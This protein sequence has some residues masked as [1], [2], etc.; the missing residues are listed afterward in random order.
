MMTFTRS[1]ARDY[2][3]DHTEDVMSRLSQK[4]QK[5]WICPFPGCDHGARDPNSDGIMLNPA[6]KDGCGLKCFKCGFAGDVFDLYQALHGVEFPE[7]LEALANDLGIEISDDYGSTYTPTARSGSAIDPKPKKEPDDWTSKYPQWREAIKTDPHARQY[8]K[9]RCIS[10]GTAVKLGMGYADNLYFAR[11]IVSPGEGVCFE[12][13]AIGKAQVPKRS[14]GKSLFNQSALFGKRD[15]FIAEG[16]FDVASLV[17]V[18]VDH[19]VGLNSTSE[20]KLFL[21]ALDTYK[22][23]TNFILALD[24]DDGGRRAAEEIKRGLKDRGLPFLSVKYPEAAPGEEPIKDPNEFLVRDREAFQKAVGEALAAAQAGQWEDVADREERPAEGTAAA[25]NDVQEWGAIKPYDEPNFPPPPVDVMPA[26]LKEYIQASADTFNVPLELPVMITLAALATA[27]QGNFCVQVKRKWIETLSLLTLVCMR[28]GSGKT[29]TMTDAIAP[30]LAWQR[31]R[32]KTEVAALEAANRKNEAIKRQRAAKTK[33][34]DKAL[35]EGSITMDEYLEGQEDMPNFV[36]EP[37]ITDIIQS[38]DCTDEKLA[39]VLAKQK[40]VGFFTSEGKQMLIWLGLYT[41]GVPAAECVLRGSCGERIQVARKTIGGSVEADDPRLS[42][43]YALQPGVL[44]SLPPKTKGI[45]RSCGFFPRFQMAYAPAKLTPF[46]YYENQMPEEVEERYGAMLQALLNHEPKRID[47]EGK[48]IP[49]KY[50]L[51][52]FTD[53]AKMRAIDYANEIQY[54][55]ADKRDKLTG[56]AEWAS[57]LRGTL[58]RIAALFYLCDAA[59][60]IDGGSL[61]DFKAWDPSFF[62]GL[63]YVEAAIKF[64]NWLVPQEDYCYQSIVFSAD[65]TPKGVL[66]WIKRKGLKEFSRRD[67]FNMCRHETAIGDKVENLQLLLEDLT[68]RN[69]IKP[70]E[71]PAAGR[72]KRGRPGSPRYSVNPAF[73]DLP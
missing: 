44:A 20:V 50:S 58:S 39:Q 12:A 38:G 72:K 4:I 22:P 31:E 46:T 55:L 33:A 48:E 32:R 68:E 47:G 11:R 34:L 24:N 51:L 27:A 21:E 14:N 6:S 3:R 19:A 13:R 18:G 1:A 29:A 67:C 61:D 2:I 49:A 5:G 41:G 8:L 16:A 37:V 70:I 69:Y 15:V 62:I 40:T 35:E 7:A 28:S 42:V 17:E 60:P 43:G 26:A 54:R 59:D 52:R 57:K 56:L 36:A 63:E 65:D 66:S 23:K 10:I 71:D 53:S 25:K 9:A 30:L 45:M 64:C 73:L